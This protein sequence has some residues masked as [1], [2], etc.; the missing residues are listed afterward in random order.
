MIGG[1]MRIPQD[2]VDLINKVIQQVV[3]AGMNAT[4]MMSSVCEG[5][6]D[7]NVAIAK[8]SDLRSD[9]EELQ[10][11]VAKILFAVAF[12]DK[13]IKD[14][15]ER[16]A[17]RMHQVEAS[18]NKARDALCEMWNA[19]RIKLDASEAR[20]KELTERLREHSISNPEVRETVW[21]L[22]EGLC[23][24]CDIPLIRNG[25]AEQLADRSNVFHVDHL[26][27]KS[28]GGPD[29]LAN[30]VPSCERCNVSKGTRSYAEFKASRV[31][32]KLTVVV[33]GA[34]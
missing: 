6:V 24:H 1:E 9:D 26:V 21:N 31:A 10:A 22:T 34:S 16:E 14:A 7:R 4:L 28:L 27:P 11:A 3:A 33:G 5:V 18:L 19:Q 17:Q 32:P 30:Y 13:T 23:F 29:H 15:I 2:V 20:N 25:E 12:E 8:I